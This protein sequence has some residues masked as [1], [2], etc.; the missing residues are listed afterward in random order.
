MYIPNPIILVLCY[1]IGPSFWPLFSGI[2]LF[3]FTLAIIGVLYLRWLS[4][5]FRLKLSILFLFWFI[6]FFVFFIGYEQLYALKLDELLEEHALVRDP[7]QFVAF[8]Y[9]QAAFW[10]TF[11]VIPMFLYA[12]LL[13]FCT[14]LT[15]RILNNFS[16]SFVLILVLHFLTFV[17]VYRWIFPGWLL[18]IS[19]KN[20]TSEFYIFE[21]DRFSI[22]QAF[23]VEILDLLLFAFFLNLFY[24]LCRNKFF[25][26][27]H[28]Q[29]RIFLLLG[30]FAATMLVFYQINLS[31]KQFC[32][33][34]RVFDMSGFVLYLLLHLNFW[35]IPHAMINFNKS[36]FS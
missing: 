10:A 16:I 5:E 11:L 17:L 2:F 12:V 29:N 33:M 21:P 32:L 24:F 13:Y 4:K 19:A 1:F 3:L 15:S 14:S 27:L 23:F 9:Y 6:L 30:F 26:F 31:C 22:V 36:L 20:L 34:L 18:S 28:K 25:Y 8:L 35:K 7:Q